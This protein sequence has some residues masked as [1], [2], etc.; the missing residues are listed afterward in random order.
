VNFKLIGVI[1]EV[2]TKISLFCKKIYYKRNA[3]GRVIDRQEKG[4]CGSGP[5]FTFDNYGF[6]V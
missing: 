1:H 6:V 4:K 3:S 2:I 5:G